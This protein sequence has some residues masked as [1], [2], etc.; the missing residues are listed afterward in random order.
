MINIENIKFNDKGLIPAI[1]QD[2]KTKEVLML[3]YMNKESLNKTIETKRTWFFSRSRQKLWN[4]GETSSNYQEVKGIK[5]D[6]DSDTLLIKVLQA[7]VA[8]HRGSYSCFYKDL[9]KTDSFDKEVESGLIKK[10]YKLL[11]DRKINPKEE[12]Y[13]NYLFEKGIDKILKKVGE[14]TSEVIIGAKNSSKS[15]TVYEISDLVYHVMVLMIEM[16]ITIEDIERELY[17]RYKV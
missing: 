11:I 13:T 10:L 14:E 7:G 6:C 15:E 1:I 9:A 5:L 8:C 3:G 17:S 12:S 16:G 2:Y 4:K